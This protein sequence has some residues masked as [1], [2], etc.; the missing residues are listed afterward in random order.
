M[1]IDPLGPHGRPD[2]RLRE[3]D[4]SE[5][6]QITRKLASW[7]ILKAAAE[8]CDIIARAITIRA[9]EVAKMDKSWIVSDEAIAFIKDRDGVGTAE[10]AETAREEKKE[11]IASL[12][13]FW[14][15]PYPQSDRGW[16]E[17]RKSTRLNSSH[18]NISYAV[19]C[20]K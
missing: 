2:P 5:N 6:L 16:R 18:A 12:N 9:S 4:I 10:A 17:D 3:Y 7:N 11:L 8:Q 14:A 20:L 1:P 15:N 19:F 13:E